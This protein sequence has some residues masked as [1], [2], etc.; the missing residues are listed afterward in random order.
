VDRGEVGS[1]GLQGE[2]DCGVE[3]CYGG[4][5]AVELDVG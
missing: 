4:V 2:R 3:I 5:D 1:W